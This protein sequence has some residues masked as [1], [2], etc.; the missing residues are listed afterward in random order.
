MVAV[1][2][3]EVGES[4]FQLSSF[5]RAYWFLF[6]FISLFAALSVFLTRT[7]S[8]LGTTD[9]VFDVL[10]IPFNLQEISIATCLLITFLGVF[11]VLWAAF[12][13]PR[14]RP[15][16]YYFI[17][18]E[19]FKRL[20]LV[21]PLVV[22]TLTLTAW[23]Y[24]TY[25]QV[26]AVIF[27]LVGF[28]LG[29]V[30]FSSILVLISRNTRIRRIILATIAYALIVFCASLASLLAVNL[31][32]IAL[33]YTPLVFFIYAMGIA[34]VFYIIATLIFEMIIPFFQRWL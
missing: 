5:L 1:P 12:A 21:I 4:E 34:S 32:T 18:V 10:G 28:C 27:S 29:I 30:I 2:V 23:I 7:F 24:I 14:D 6:F 17:G 15:I 8:G 33:F 19:A 31:R 13:E 16:F 20:L 22:L 26:L 11:A 3:I 25:T 9:P